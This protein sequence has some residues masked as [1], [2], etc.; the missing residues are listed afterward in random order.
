MW[1]QAEHCPVEMKQGFL[2]HLRG[3]KL[4]DSPWR[5]M[6]QGAEWECPPPV[7]HVGMEACVLGTETT[8]RK[9]LGLQLRWGQLRSPSCLK[10]NHAASL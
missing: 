2:C 7:T 10:A 9:G 5:A 6:T 4:Y 3:A 1:L 8:G